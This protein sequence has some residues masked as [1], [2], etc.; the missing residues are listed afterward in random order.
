MNVIQSAT[1]SQAYIRCRAIYLL[2]YLFIK[3]I[4]CPIVYSVIY[5]LFCVIN[6]YYGYRNEAQFLERTGN[7]STQLIHIASAAP[8]PH[9]QCEP[10]L[11]PTRT[12]PEG[13]AA[14]S[15]KICSDA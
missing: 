10:R 14:P 8:E 3:L 5:L 7:L 9:I 2:I 11:F 4:I 1:D 12:W 13:Q 15:L 6:Y